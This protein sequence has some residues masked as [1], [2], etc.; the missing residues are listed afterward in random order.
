MYQ[1]YRKTKTAFTEEVLPA[2]CFVEKAKTWSWTLI[3]LLVGAVVYAV[4]TSI[5]HNPDTT[6][7]A[8]AASS[9]QGA[10]LQNTA[11]VR[12]PYCPGFLDAKERCNVFEC[13]IYSPNWGK[14]L[15]SPDIPVKQVL[16]RELAIEVGASAGKSSVIVHSVYTGGNGEKAGLRVGDRI[17]LFNGR[18]VKNVKQFKSIVARANP[19]SKI[20]IQA[21]RNGREIKSF[22]MIGEGGRESAT[23]PKTVR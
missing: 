12:C 3:I 22:V 20:K 10:M 1:A 5:G 19:E 4:V 14:S 2:D 18:K 7:P 16:L 6:Y 21:I 17:L 8:A 15:S 9:A 11:L 13:P 23:V